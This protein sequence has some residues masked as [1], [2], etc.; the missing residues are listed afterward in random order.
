[1]RFAL[2]Y[3]D[4]RDDA[5][6]GSRGAQATSDGKGRCAGCTRPPFLEVEVTV[7]GRAIGQRGNKQTRSTRIVSATNRCGRYESPPAMRHRSRATAFDRRALLHDLFTAAHSEPVR[8]AARGVSAFW[9]EINHKNLSRLSANNHSVGTKIN[10]LTFRD[11]PTHRVFA[12][13]T[14]AGD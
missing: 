2:D 12:A 11:A 5:A 13:S 8:D 10:E 7:L 1:M 6:G 14:F 9:D 3:F 4:C